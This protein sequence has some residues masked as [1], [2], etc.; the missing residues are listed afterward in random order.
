[1]DSDD[2]TGPVSEESCSPSL[3]AAD[4]PEVDSLSLGLEVDDSSV[5]NEVVA[6]PSLPPLEEEDSGATPGEQLAKRAVRA[7]ADK[8]INDRFIFG[9]PLQK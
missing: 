6:L 7:T 4:S 2:S 8:R 1:M 5:V 9:P 3:Q